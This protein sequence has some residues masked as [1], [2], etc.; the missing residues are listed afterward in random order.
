VVPLTIVAFRSKVQGA[1][2]PAA[3]AVAV[4]ISPDGSRP[5]TERAMTALGVDSYGALPV[6]ALARYDF[7]G[8]YV[9]GSTG[10]CIDQFEVPA[11]HKAGKSLI[12]VYEDAAADAAG[13]ANAGAAKAVIARP[14]L[15]AINWPVGRPVYFACDMPGYAADLPSF[16]ACA[17]TFAKGIV[18]PA[19]IYGDVTT[20]TYAYEHGIR[21]L[22]QFGE[23]RAPGITVYQ[24]RPIVVDG[25]SVDPDEAFAA[26]YGQ[27]APTPVP[28][29][30]TEVDMIYTLNPNYLVRGD[31]K[32]GI[33]NPAALDS[34]RAQG[35]PEKKLTAEQLGALATVPWGQL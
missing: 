14:V 32:T 21:Y 28:T 35:I 29:P 3:A 26:D 25:Y 1:N 18:R 4:S 11:Y 22:W 5:G 2:N 17:E 27:W 24:S 8:R 20:C 7:I 31:K 10:K 23:G 6:S 19:A 34:L 30:S 9:S 15:R 33:P 12:L 13:G 16:V